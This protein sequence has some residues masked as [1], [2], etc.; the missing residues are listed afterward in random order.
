[1]SED[2][3]RF[4][5]DRYDEAEA[6]ALA[7]GN[8]AKGEWG[9][10]LHPG[11][12]GHLLDGLG[13]VVIYDEGS[14]ADEQFDYIAAVDPAHRLADVKLKR[15]ILAEHEHVKVEFSKGRRLRLPRLRQRQRVRDERRRLVRHRPPARHR[16]HQPPRLQARVGT[17]RSLMGTVTPQVVI[18]AGYKR[19]E[20]LLAFLGLPGADVTDIAISWNRGEGQ[21]RQYTVSITALGS[22]ETEGETDGT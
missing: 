18:D 13:D 9:P 7:A 12:G 1:M 21:R 22:T 11:M 3:A 2:L 4:L 17:G 8:G 15:A 19:A 20:E 16:V 10:R 14:P 6:L 5:A